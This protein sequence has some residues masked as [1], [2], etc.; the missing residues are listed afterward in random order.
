MFEAGRGQPEAQRSAVI[1]TGD[2]AMQ[3]AGRERIAGTDAV[4]D[5]R[6]ID[7]GRVV[8]RSGA[9]EEHGRQGVMVDAVLVTN[10][11]GQTLQFRECLEG[12]SGGSW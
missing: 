3:D 11:A 8:D 7:A 12:S 9:G 2:D 10:G 4:D 6:Q 1:H 5:V